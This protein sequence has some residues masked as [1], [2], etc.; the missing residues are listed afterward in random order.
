MPVFEYRCTDCNNTYDV[1]HLTK[2]KAE[3]IV[4]PTCGSVQ[5]KKLMSVPAAYGEKNSARD[6]SPAP[7][8]GGGCCGGGA[9]GIN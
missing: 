2:E 4:C 5:H 9:C 8:Y 6:F 7:S 3:D 1:L